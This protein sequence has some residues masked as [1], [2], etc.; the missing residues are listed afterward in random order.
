M[1]WVQLLDPESLP[2]DTRAIAESGEAQ[3]GQLLETWRALFHRPEIFAAYLPFLR[4]VAG[5]GSVDLATKDLSALLV[6]KLNGCRYTVSHRCASAARNGV[7][8][9]TVELVVSGKWDE[10]EPRLRRTLQYTRMLTISP[11]AVPYTSE[12]GLLP[13]WLRSSLSQWYSED[14]IVELTLSISVWNAL[15]RFHRVMQFELDMPAPPPS[16]DPACVPAD[17]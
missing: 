11:P 17:A 6:A 16:A 7:P 9:R 8:P 5:P 3:Y 1:S 13:S 12:P 10:L 15:S 4:A 14:Q 2:P